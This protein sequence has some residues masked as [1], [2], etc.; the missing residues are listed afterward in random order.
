MTSLYKPT[1]ANAEAIESPAGI[2]LIPCS[3]GELSDSGVGIGVSSPCVLTDAPVGEKQ[4]KTM[5]KRSSPIN[6]LPDSLQRI[7]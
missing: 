7:V 2:I 6:R 4:E 1:F 3:C 5:F